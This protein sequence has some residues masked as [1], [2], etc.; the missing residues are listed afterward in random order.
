MTVATEAL[1]NT[2]PGAVATGCWTQRNILVIGPVA[3]APGSVFVYPRLSTVIARE[4]HPS[5]QV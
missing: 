3:T 4:L 2:E 5:F 1:T